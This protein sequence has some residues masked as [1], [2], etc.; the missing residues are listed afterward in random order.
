[1]DRRNHL[2]RR[3]GFPQSAKNGEQHEGGPMS[4]V[5]LATAQ[6]DHG[7][8]YCNAWGVKRDDVLAILWFYGTRHRA[9]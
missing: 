7:V 2:L 9:V 3:H 5:R 6:A 8:M 4:C 1:M